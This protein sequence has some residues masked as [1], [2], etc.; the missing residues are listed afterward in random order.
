MAPS[1]PQSEAA[2][3]TVLI[4]DDEPSTRAAL[5]TMVEGL[6]A[7]CR[8]LEAADGATALRL[9]NSLS[10][11]LVLLDIVLPGSETSGVL[12]CQELCKS[13]TKVLIV[14]ANASGSIAQACLAMGAADILHKPFS[15]ED[16]R[17]LIASCLGL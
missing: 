16:A 5:R 11:D 9:A 14:S 6:P 13:H 17:A 8:V 4:V 2:G 15:V 7:P 12:V 10:P 3:R 1:E